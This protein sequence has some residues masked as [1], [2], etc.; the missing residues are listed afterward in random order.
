MLSGVPAASASAPVLTPAVVGQATLR[1]HARLLT[2]KVTLTQPFSP[3]QLASQGRSLCLLLDN[4]HGGPTGQTCVIGPRRGHRHP[5][6]VYESLTHGH[7][8]KGRVISAQVTRG[9][10]K[11]LTA[12]FLPAAVGER[13]RSFRWQV[14]TTLK[15][16]TCTATPGAGTCARFFPNRPYKVPLHV[17]RLVGCVNRGA[18]FVGHG[19]RRGRMIAFTFD[20]GPWYDTTQFLH[21]LEH[22]HVPATFFEI[23]EQISVYGHGGSVERRML[24]DGDMVG[25]HTW[26]HPDVAGGGSFARGQLARTAAAIKRATHGFEPCLFRAPY[27]SVSPALFSVARSLGLKTIQWDIDPRD[28]ATP[29]TGAIVGNVL[30]N[31]HPGAIILQHDGGGNRSQTLAALPQEIRALRRRGYHFVTITRLLGMRLIYR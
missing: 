31:A 12:S 8:S 7:P 17:P 24:A 26:S 4:L 29:G 23:G 10:A 19:P 21:I 27:G 2:W 14:R 13:Y 18:E 5:R 15:A 9:S 25:D 20:D 16:P 28:W 3:G 30:A 6:L 22:Y 1:Q 11:S